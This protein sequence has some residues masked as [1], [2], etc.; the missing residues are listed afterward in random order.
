MKTVYT[1]G[2]QGLKVDALLKFAELHDALVLD[3]RMSPMARDASWRKKALMTSLGNRYRHAEQF[4]NV[5]YKG[6][7]IELKDPKQGIAKV[8]PILLKQPVILLCACWNQ[9]ECHRTVVADLIR[10][11]YQVEVV[12]LKAS[13]FPKPPKA[14]PK[15][16]AQ[17]TLF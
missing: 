10:D 14:P 17:T 7:P 12:H 11:T 2:Y 9:R 5:N 8:G 13:D 16:P 15:P 6:G 1:A 4:G 3:V